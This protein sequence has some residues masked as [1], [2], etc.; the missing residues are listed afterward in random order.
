MFDFVL[1]FLSVPLVISSASL[2]LECMVEWRTKFDD[3]NQAGMTIHIY[4][5]CWHM[6]S[7]TLFPSPGTRSLMGVKNCPKHFF[8]NFT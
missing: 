7:F 8:G 1:K 4:N 2:Y 3:F 5:S 6:L